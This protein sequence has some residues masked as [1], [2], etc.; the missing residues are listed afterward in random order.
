[1]AGRSDRS[2]ALTA[3]ACGGKV[4]SGRGLAGASE[5]AS[6]GHPSCVSFTAMASAFLV[7][8]ARPVFERIPYVTKALWLLVILLSV[9]GPENVSSRGPKEQLNCFNRSGTNRR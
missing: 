2:S 7:I 6:A 9:L 1:V 8:P 5:D 3:L 4:E